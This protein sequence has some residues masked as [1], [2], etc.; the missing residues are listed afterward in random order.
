MVET[1]ELCTRA[2]RKCAGRALLRPATSC[3]MAAAWPHLSLAGLSRVA[4]SEWP[5]GTI[6]QAQLA[7]SNQLICMRRC[8]AHAPLLWRSPFGHRC[9]LAVGSLPARRPGGSPAELRGQLAA[10]RSSATTRELSLGGS[11]LTK[12]TTG[13]LLRSRLALAAAHRPSCTEAGGSIVRA[14][15]KRAQGNRNQQAA[16]PCPQLWQSGT[17][18]PAFAPTPIYKYYYFSPYHHDHHHYYYCCYYYSSPSSLGPL[19]PLF[20][21]A[22]HL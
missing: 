19:F 7:A 2:A 6:A 21:L 13:P 10:R 18:S 5:S 16:G 20:P 14:L 8:G 4:S 17:L 22:H 12:V 1:H 3:K 15:N 9:K 11:T